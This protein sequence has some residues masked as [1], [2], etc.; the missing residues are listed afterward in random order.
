MWAL[1]LA[2]LAIIVVWYLGKKTPVKEYMPED[3]DNKE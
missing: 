2:I 1:G 3:D